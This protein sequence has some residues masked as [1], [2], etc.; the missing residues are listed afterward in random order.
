MEKKDSKT[1]SVQEVQQSSPEEEWMT[2]TNKKIW[3]KSVV[4]LSAKELM[5]K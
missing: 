5:D 2:M 3:K 1:I 4:A